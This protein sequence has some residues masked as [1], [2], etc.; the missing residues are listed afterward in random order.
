MTKKICVVL[1]SRANYGRVKSVMKAI[2][3]HPELTLQLVCSS[4]ANLERYGNVADIVVKDG[5]E[6]HRKLYNLTEGENLI[7]QCKTVSSALSDLSN[8]FNDLSPDAVITVADRHETIATAIAASFMNIPLIHIQGGEESGNI[9]DKVRH[10]ITKMADYHFPATE[11]SRNRIIAMGEQPDRVFNFGCPAMDIAAKAVKSNTV[12]LSSY[13]GI[14]CDMDWDKSYI[15]VIHHPDTKK[16]EDGFNQVYSILK[17]LLPLSDFQKV[18]L[19]PNSDA[20][21]ASNSKAIRKFREFDDDGTYAYFKNF[22]PEN[23]VT[24]LAGAELCVGNSSSFIREAE[25]LAVPAVIVG[26][27]QYSREHGD[28]V[29]F[30]E[31]NIDDI[32]LQIAKA[33]KLHPNSESIFGSG[34][35]GELIANKIAETKLTTK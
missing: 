13:Q 34:V 18:V 11:Q 33:L 24:L 9:D 14:G 28:N 7:T 16:Y 29:I 35:A 1:G 3:L 4:S 21:S 25:F 22:S 17:S 26:E 31:T 20:G 32:S 10:A 6:I 12:D 23:F 2:K 8:V 5:Y 27:R 30:S 19:W 15:L